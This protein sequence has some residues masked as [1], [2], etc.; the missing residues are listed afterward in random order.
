MHYRSRA[1]LTKSC[2]H[3]YRILPNNADA[4][5]GCT[6]TYIG[7]NVH[8]NWLLSPG[9]SS[10]SEGYSSKWLFRLVCGEPLWSMLPHSPTQDR[11]RIVLGYLRKRIS[12]RNVPRTPMGTIIYSMCLSHPT[13]P[14]RVGR[15]VPK[16]PLDTIIHTPIHVSIPTHCP[17]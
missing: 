12:H 13:V 7:C 4:K 14:C 15:T 5:A 2:S 9:K 1:K 16:T 11:Y 3:F 6:C 10:Q 17:M 8:I